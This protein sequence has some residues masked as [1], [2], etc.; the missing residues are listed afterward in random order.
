LFPVSCTISTTCLHE[1]TRR[2]MHNKCFLCLSFSR[3]YHENGSK[4]L[5]FPS[6]L[7]WAPF[8]QRQA[9]YPS[10]AMPQKM[11][12]HTLPLSLSCFIL[13]T[14]SSVL[15]LPHVHPPHTQVHCNVWSYMAFGTAYASWLTLIHRYASSTS[16]CRPHTVVVWGHIH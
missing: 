4:A 15:P 12:I 5:T 9:L 8:V 6:Q 16:S 14:S 2:M 13:C 1:Q 11:I 10:S 3:E 7:A